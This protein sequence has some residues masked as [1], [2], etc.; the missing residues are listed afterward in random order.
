MAIREAPVA[1]PLYPL[2][3][4]HS[5]GTLDAEIF[6]GSSICQ[7]AAET[8]MVVDGGGGP[9]RQRHDGAAVERRT[10]ELAADEL[11]LA[12]AQ[13][14]CR[15]MNFSEIVSLFETLRTLG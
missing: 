10:I 1:L 12:G 11:H 8:G 13:L 5:V 6:I 2:T 9:R 15:A 3:R 7:S 4:L 14:V